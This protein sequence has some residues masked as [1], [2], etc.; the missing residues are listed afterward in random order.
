MKDFVKSIKY[1]IKLL[2]MKRTLRRMKGEL[3]LCKY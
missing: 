1:R 3:K 2:K